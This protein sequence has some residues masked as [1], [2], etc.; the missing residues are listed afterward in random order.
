MGQSDFRQRT[1]EAERN[2]EPSPDQ[3]PKPQPDAETRRVLGLLRG[4][5]DRL[6]E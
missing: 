2:R 6:P 4:V 1:V 5:L 3:Q